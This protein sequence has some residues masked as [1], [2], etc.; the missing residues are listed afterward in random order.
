MDDKKA[1]NEAKSLGLACALTSDVLRYADDLGLI[2]FKT[3]AG[4]LHSAA[5]YLPGV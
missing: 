3:I 5:I 2:D 1:R 4:K